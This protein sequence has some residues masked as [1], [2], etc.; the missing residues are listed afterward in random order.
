MMGEIIRTIPEKCVQCYACVR[1]C[2]VKAVAIHDGKARIIQERCIQCGN[3]VKICSQNAKEVLNGINTTL[4]FLQQGNAVALLAPSFPAAFKGRPQKV[5]AG[6]RAIGFAEVWEVAVGAELVVEACRSLE[7]DKHPYISSACP[8]VINLIERHYS[9][10]MSYLI[11]VVSPVIA[12]ARLI[13]NCYPDKHLNMV[14]IG[15]CIAKKGEIRQPSVRGDIQEALTYT[16]L[17]ELFKLKEIKWSDLKEEPFDS[18]AASLA[19][20][21]PLSGGLL[22]NLNHTQDILR[23]DYIVIDGMRNWL[24]ILEILD[25]RQDPICLIDGLFCNGCIDGPA[26]NEKG[27]VLARKSSLLRYVREIPL[28]RQAE[29]KAWL[30]NVNIDLSRKFQ[31]LKVSLPQPSEKDILNILSKTGKDRPED[32]M[33]CGACGYPSCREKA[34]AVYQGIAEMEMCLPYL[35]TQKSLLVESLDRELKLIRELKGELDILID[36]SYD[37]ICMTDGQGNIQR[38]NRTFEQL[39]EMSEEKLLGVNL[40][41]LEEKNILFP[42]AT[43]AVARAKKAVTFFQRLG[44]G[45][46]VLATGNPVMDDDGNIIRIIAN[47]RDFDLL[48]KIK[49]ELDNVYYPSRIEKLDKDNP[50]IALSQE[51]TSLLDMAARVAIADSTVLILGESG[52]GKEVIARYIHKNS[53]RSQGPFVK[54]NC[55][56][57]PE[58]L[59]ESELFGYETGAFTGARPKG[60]PGLFEVAHKGTLLLDEIGELPLA[61]QAKLLQVIQE[62]QITR[63]GGTKPQS[64]DVR[65]LAATNR[66]LPSMVKEGKF[67]ADLF[68]RL[69]VIPIRIPPIR[70]R[71]DDIIPLMYFF[72]DRYNERYQKHCKVSKE[73]K[74]VFLQYYWPGNVRELENMVERLVVIAQKDVIDVDDLPPVLKKSQEPETAVII[75][76]ILPL[77][78]AIEETERQI[79]LQARELYDSTYKIAEAL[80]INQSTVVRKLKK[81]FDYSK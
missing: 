62:K 78:Q 23:E 41:L 55:S 63:I 42:S 56:A 10:F 31:D 5:A 61:Q 9:K 1:N 18:P 75:R 37:G 81:Y 64:I 39:V 65:L 38:V 15:P 27:N 59:I 67:R 14:F 57:L 7:L 17:E 6:L 60:K 72:L 46:R 22:R 4:N 47:L 13:R 76:G 16:E 21:F 25:K 35:L 20:I 2:P 24:D 68:Y 45:K 19:Y 80:E 49:G 36:A 69:N 43:M 32:Q 77:K 70:E 30:L 33:N 66:D 79:L 40:S 26:M 54:I 44:S 73:V 71:K 29:G 12:T 50:I 58:S 28:E 51:F 11:P 53:P 3:C 8:A 34:I 48:H 52:V 74:E